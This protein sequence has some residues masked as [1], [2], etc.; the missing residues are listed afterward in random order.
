MPKKK[1]ARR[2][3][4]KTKKTTK[5]PRAKAAKRTRKAAPRRKPAATKPAKKSRTPRGTSSAA[6]Q[7]RSI[8]FR[9]KRPGAETAGQSGD[10]EGLRKVA[11]ANSESVEELAEEGQSFEADVVAG[12]EEAEDAEESE[13]VTHEVPEDD[14][15]SE[16]DD[17]E[18]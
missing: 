8:A 13:V 5:Q 7:A 6:G 3:A 2:K 9:P 16:Y 15:P 10:I 4:T 18:H 1:A 11:R 12:V 17:N 14:V